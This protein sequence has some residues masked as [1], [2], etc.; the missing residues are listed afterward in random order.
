ME[1]IDEQWMI[2]ETLIPVKELSKEGKGRPRIK[3]R[4]VLNG[5]LWVHRS[6]AVLQDLP[7]SYTY[8][9]T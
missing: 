7:D 8:P 6:I 4:D 3:N 1:L 5:I 9:A 2:I